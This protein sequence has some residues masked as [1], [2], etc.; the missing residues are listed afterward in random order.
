M[1][2]KEPKKALP[3]PTGKWENGLRLTRDVLGVV[4]VATLV[5]GALPLTAISGGS[6]LL[7]HVGYESARSARREPVAAKEDNK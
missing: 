2:E 4:A 7:A 1:A 3:G 5:F 6:A